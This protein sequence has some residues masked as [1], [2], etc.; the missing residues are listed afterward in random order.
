MVDTKG[1]SF[2]SKALNSWDK[3]TLVLQISKKISNN[4]PLNGPLKTP[5]IIS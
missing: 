3:K 1:A 2:C 5:G 4:I